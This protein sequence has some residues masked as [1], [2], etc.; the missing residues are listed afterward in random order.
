M[1]NLSELFNLTEEE[2]EKILNNYMSIILSNINKKDYSSSGEEI[3]TLSNN[4]SVTTKSYV[5][6]LDSKQLTHIY[7]DVL[8]N[9]TKDEINSIKSNANEYIELKEKQLKQ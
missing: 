6:T 2:K 9:L 1:I 3:I 8:D 7:V 5:L 4:Q